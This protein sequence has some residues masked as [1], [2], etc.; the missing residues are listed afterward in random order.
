M[1][2]ETLTSINFG[3]NNNLEEVY[4]NANPFS[5]LNFDQT[6]NLKTLQVFTIYSDPTFTGAFSP[7]DITV[8][9]SQNNMLETLKT[10]GYV[11][12]SN[13]QTFLANFTL[14]NIDQ[15]SHLKECLFKASKFVSPISINS[16]DF[17]TFDASTD[18]YFD[19][20]EFNT[21]NLNY[22][23]L[24]FY[25]VSSLQ[26]SML[27]DLSL[28][29]SSVINPN[30][31][32]QNLT[33]P[34]LRFV[35][36]KNGI[37]NQQVI[38]IEN[39]DQGMVFCVDTVDQI[40]SNYPLGWYSWHL[41]QNTTITTNCSLHEENFELENTIKIYPNP[42]QNFI[43]INSN[44]SIS[45][46]EIYDLTGRIILSKITSDDRIDISNFKSGNYI[47][48]VYTEKDFSKFKIIKK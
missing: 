38:E 8:N 44:S 39:D 32:I 27:S 14:N 9:L 23:S 31:N 11:R 6:P 15:S 21:P 40:G 24:N 17:I 4:I 45:K 10:K 18:S 34:T 22:F 13:N 12:D 35:S 28:D 41:P 47:L 42:V 1:T 20:L 48:K 33:Y 7:T 43:F 2:Q 37:V 5:T 29:F 16:N 36:I 30:F 26:P 19:S 3:E 25:P 46:I